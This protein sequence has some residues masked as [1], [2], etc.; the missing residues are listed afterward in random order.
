VRPA[1][2]YYAALLAALLGLG[3]LLITAPAADAAPRGI[4]LQVVDG[5]LGIGDLAVPISGDEVGNAVLLATWD[6]ETGRVTR[7]TF[8][9]PEQQIDL[10]ELTPILAGQMLDVSITQPRPATGNINRTTGAGTLNLALQVNLSTASG[11]IPSGC[12]V[13]IDLSLRTNNGGTPFTFS[14]GTPN[15]GTLRA[16][17]ISVPELTVA[18]CGPLVPGLANP[19]LGL[20]TDAATAQLAVQK[21]NPIA[22]S[23]PRNVRAV[24]QTGAAQVTWGAPATRGDFPI[25]GYTVTAAPG[26]RTCT[27]SGP[28]E[29]V[30]GGLTNGTAYTF[31]VRAR[32][33]AGQGPASA[34]SAAVTPAGRPGRVTGV[35]AT[36]LTG[37]ARINWTALTGPGTG[38]ARITDYQARAAEATGKTCAGGPRATTCTITG[39]RR[40]Q[41]L[42]FQ[43]RAKNAVGWG[44]WSTR[45]A[46]VTIR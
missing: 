34:P 26:G 18:D 30:V 46:V 29:C 24:A 31:T 36:P 33:L 45:T 40:G 23:A 37:A 44:P 38:G 17:N 28:R 5:V 27:T 35:T 20:P 7:G 42:S 19:A 41:R 39:L 21:L 12:N 9:V 3:A 16:T 2:R 22:P 1:R 25:T 13:R 10:G 15:T 11:L 14:G 8:T 43:V 6:N 4:K 32:S